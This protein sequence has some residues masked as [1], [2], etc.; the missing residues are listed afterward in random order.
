MLQLWVQMRLEL[1]LFDTTLPPYHVNP[2]YSQANQQLFLGPEWALSQQRIRPSASWA[3]WAIDSWAIDSEAMRA[4]GIIV[5]VKSNQLVKNVKNKKNFSWLKLDFNPFLLP[6]TVR[7]SLLIGYNII[8][9]Q[10]QL[11]RSERSIDNR[12][13]VGFY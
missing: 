13:L 1:T 10:Q 9:A 8:I 6:K 5:L 7:F 3:S 4:R 11:S 2:C 12:P